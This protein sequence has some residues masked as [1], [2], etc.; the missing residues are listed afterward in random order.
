M[1]KYFFYSD[2]IK[3]ESI[4]TAYTLS[5]LQKIK[6]DVHSIKKVDQYHL[7]FIANTKNRNRIIQSFPSAKIINSIGL[8]N[9]IKHTVFK[10]T[11]LICLLISLITFTYLNNK[12]MEVQINGDASNL[13]DTLKVE[14]ASHDISV[15]KNKKEQQE[16]LKIEKAVAKTLYEKIE[17]IEIRQTG[18][19]IKV[20]FLKRRKSIEDVEKKDGLYATKDGMVR[21]FR[22]S[23]G[24]KQVSEFQYVTKGT[25]LISD[26]IITTK[27]QEIII[28]AYGSVYANTWYTLSAETNVNENY[29]EIDLYLELLEK[30]HQ[31]IDK[32]IDGDDEYIEDESIIQFKVNEGKA[33]LKVHYTLLEDIT[34]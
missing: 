28:G 17:W 6:I 24:V 8:F 2:I 20:K 27:E 33:I 26:K 18:V 14:L 23:Y 34:R 13:V 12:I 31:K 29:N 4:D 5:V 3:V 16:L 9:I 30:I 15:F 19:I 10:V 1:K 32:E 25:L 22:I 11:T 21:F 7:Q